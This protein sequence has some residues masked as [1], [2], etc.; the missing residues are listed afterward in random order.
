MRCEYS[1]VLPSQKSLCFFLTCNNPVVNFV[2]PAQAGILCQISS[3]LGT[4]P[5]PPP[6]LHSSYKQA[7]VIFPGP[8]FLNFNN[9]SN[10][11]SPQLLLNMRNTVHLSFF[12][13]SASF[14]SV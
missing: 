12:N 5:T 9:T 2:T 13:N 4:T 10:G 3:K 11:S 7:T 14:P 1:T 6:G 8:S